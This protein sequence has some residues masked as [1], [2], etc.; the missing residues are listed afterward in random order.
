M[1]RLRAFLDRLRPEPFQLDS[2]KRNLQGS[3]DPRVSSP[4]ME[5]KGSHRFR[6]IPV[7][8]GILMLIGAFLSACST[9][10]T[11]VGSPPHVEG[12]TFVG[13][14]ACV[15]CH[16]NYTR[17][18]AS[19]AHGRFHKDDLQW[20]G[21]SGCESCHGPGSLHVKSPGRGKFIVNPGKKP[22]T[23]FECH[24]EVHAQMTLPNH[25]PVLEGKLSCVSC[26]DPHGRDAL[27]PARTGLA[28]ARQNE[29]C[30]N[31][32]PAQSRPFVY[33]H[34]AMRDGCVS[35][36]Q[37]HGAV[38]SKLLVAADNNLCLKCHAQIQ[39]ASGQWLIGKMDHSQFANRGTCWTAGCHS[40]VHGSNI[41]PKLQY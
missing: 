25:H 34:E 10:D 20:A 22:E 12:A 33:E 35:C 1:D 4:S 36:H 41:N 5:T 37:P 16:A 7:L 38:N 31:C 30:A 26:H 27:K 11:S 32:H 13:N 8:M 39:S 24:Q 21:H 14:Q 40:A 9:L 29:T 19:S 15:D 17:T 28:M 6:W 23:C 2:S 18:F 3:T